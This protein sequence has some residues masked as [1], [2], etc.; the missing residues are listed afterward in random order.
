[1]SLPRYLFSCNEIRTDFY[2]YESLVSSIKKVPIY[3]GTVF[4]LKFQL[5][6]F[7]IET[8]GRRDDNLK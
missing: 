2:D 3:T 5:L 8:N 6:S 7:Q 1:M 4:F